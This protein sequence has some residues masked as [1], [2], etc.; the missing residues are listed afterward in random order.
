METIERND[1]TTPNGIQAEMKR[2]EKMIGTPGAHASI[3]L[4]SNVGTADICLDA[5]W[6]RSSYGP[7]VR[8]SRV[9]GETFAEMIA[10]AEQAIRNWQVTRYNDVIRKLALAIIELTDEHTL[11][12]ETLLRGKGFS[13][14]DIVE[15]SERA[16]A[17][18]SEMAGAAPF[19]V[20]F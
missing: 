13:A 17:R 14:A 2:L 6:C 12:T 5:N 18:A 3:V 4:D 1:L 11:C 9:K 16:C 15:Y 8:I 19:R 10:S 20:L 7:D